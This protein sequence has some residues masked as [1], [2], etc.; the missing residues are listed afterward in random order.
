MLDEIMSSAAAPIRLWS[1]S[2][3]WN[4]AARHELHVSHIGAKRSSLISSEGRGS[5]RLLLKHSTIR[6]TSNIRGCWRR[7]LQRHH[8]TS[9]RNT[10][11]EA[12]MPVPRAQ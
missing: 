6:Y 10:P 7:Y 9:E 11:Q 3:V 12:C 2:A 5:G 4:C 1:A 8:L